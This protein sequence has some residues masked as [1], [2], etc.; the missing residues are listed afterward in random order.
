MKKISEV[1]QEV[2]LSERRIR[3]YERAGLIRPQREPRTNDRLFGEVEICQL[4][5]LKRLVNEKKFT[6]ENLK[7]LLSYAPCWELK[8]CPHRDECPV[9]NNP[10]TPCYL[11]PDHSCDSDDCE[12]CPIYLSKEQPRDRLVLSSDAGN[13]EH[14]PGHSGDPRPDTDTDEPTRP[15]EPPADPT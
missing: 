2:G 12:R 15:V 11:Q 14:A 8:A 7:T 10:A 6:L 5:L 4:M 3:E 13:G 1:S 9:L